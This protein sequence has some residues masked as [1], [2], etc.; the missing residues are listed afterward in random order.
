M[1]LLWQ[2][3]KWANQFPLLLDP[4]VASKVVLSGLKCRVSFKIDNKKNEIRNVQIFI[5]NWLLKH[6]KHAAN[7]LAWAV[8]ENSQGGDMRAGHSQGWVCVCVWC[9]NSFRLLSSLVRSPIPSF[10]CVSCGRSWLADA[11]CA[12]GWGVGCLQCDVEYFS[13]LFCFS[14]DTHRDSVLI[15]DCSAVGLCVG[16]VWS[17]E[18]GSWSASFRLFL[19][20]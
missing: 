2:S 15:R 4:P 9:D 13:F 14:V 11:V 5:Q 18:R 1:L 17:R 16:S 8:G 20:F 12:W 6:S 7:R 10:S 3:A 19:L